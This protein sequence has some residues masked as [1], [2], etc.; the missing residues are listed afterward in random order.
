[1]RLS[2]VRGR[3]SNPQSNPQQQTGSGQEFG[4]IRHSTTYNRPFNALY[5][6]QPVKVLATGDIAGMSPALQIVDEQ[7][8]VD[9]VSEE[10]VTITQPRCVPK[11]TA[12]QL[13][14]RGQQQSR[15]SQFAGA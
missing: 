15:Q 3:F 12:Q 11:S 13:R 14:S 6:N 4:T 2:D 8:K 9:W 10:D 7:G 5:L 1:M